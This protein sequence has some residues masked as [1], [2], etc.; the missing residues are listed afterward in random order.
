MAASP[1]VSR[2]N[3]HLRLSSLIMPSIFCRLASTSPRSVPRSVVA[4]RTLALMPCAST[5]TASTFFRLS[6][7]SASRPLSCTTVARASFM[8][9]S[10]PNT[11]VSALAARPSTRASSALV[12]SSAATSFCASASLPNI[13]PSAPRGPL[14]FA[15][16]SCRLSSVARSP[17]SCAVIRLTFSSTS[18]ADASTRG[19]SAVA[20]PRSAVRS[21]PSGRGGSVS[22]PE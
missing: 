20:S 17:A 7:V 11:C 8:T 21:A 4:P 10:G 5:S 18:L 16:T 22:T 3:G 19:S 6:R 1:A 13:T 2:A 12:R 9:P 14:S 15:V